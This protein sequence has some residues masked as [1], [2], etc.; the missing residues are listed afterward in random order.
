[1][2]RISILILTCT[3]L[4]GSELEWAGTW[5]TDG[6]TAVTVRD[7]IAYCAADSA[8][9]DI[10]ALDGGEAVRLGALQLPGN[11]LGLALGPD[12][13]WLA[14]AD[15]GLHVIDI[16]D[17]GR[18]LHITTLDLGESVLGVVGDEDRVFALTSRTLTLID[19]SVPS[20]PVIIE[21]HKFFSAARDLVIDGSLVH[22]V[23]GN[24][25][26]FTIDVGG[27]GPAVPLAEIALEDGAYSIARDGEILVI[28]GRS[29]V[30]FFDTSGLK[31]RRV[32]KVPLQFAL[33]VAA[34]NGRAIAVGNGTLLEIDFRDATRPR[35][36]A[37]QET[38][39][40]TLGIA[41][42]GT[43]PVLAQND[44]GL[45][46]LDGTGARLSQRYRF[47]ESGTIERIGLQRRIVY[48]AGT[49]GLRLVNA[50]DPMRPDPVADLGL[51]YAFSAEGEAGRIFLGGGDSVTTLYLDRRGEPVDVHV[52]ENQPSVYDLA[53]DG[54]MVWLLTETP[55]SGPGITGLDT[56]RGPTRFFDVPGTPESLAGEGG[57]LVAGLGEAGL[58]TIDVSD[59]SQP[60]ALGRLQTSSPVEHLLL[61]GR[62]G[63]AALGEAGIGVVDLSD[64]ARPHITTSEPVPGGAERSASGT[65]R[66]Y[67]VGQAGLWVYDVTV[68][69]S[70]VF[71][72]HHGIPGGAIDVAV[73]HGL[74]VV[75]GTRGRLALFRAEREVSTAYATRR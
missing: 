63:Y 56:L 26:L 9:L 34:E 36:T 60:V 46:V 40:Y 71:V 42:D 1:M 25:R 65:E 19:A 2:I 43:R 61:E 66:L 14:A 30:S 72:E 48:I 57:L 67:V 24:G 68:P 11:A 39:V 16:A 10:L 47:D 49:P 62:I 52:Y 12:H 22:V 13:L 51:P 21:Q 28:G 37:R 70:P 58:L 35:V 27:D 23:D 29:T 54:E 59:P 8:G 5:G 53:P 33:A 4:Y 44:D 64:P 20:D 69:E 15:A 41:F 32:G 18:P 74:V 7:G 17:P 38:A 73:S 6:F 50:A 55:L 31:P 75:A 45:A 3:T